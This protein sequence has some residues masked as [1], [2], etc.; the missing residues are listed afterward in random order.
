MKIH[1]LLLLFLLPLASYADNRRLYTEDQYGANWP[2]TVSQGYLSCE[3]NA[4]IFIVNDGDIYGV[5]GVANSTHKYLSLD[6][7]W[8]DDQR[9]YMKGAKISLP[10][11]FISDGL[12][13]CN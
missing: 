7:I 8:K 5:N 9:P 1:S 11:N 10:D 3:D 13:L 12:T 2:F 4:V 6:T